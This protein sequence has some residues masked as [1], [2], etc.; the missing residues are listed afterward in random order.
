MSEST[1]LKWLIFSHRLQL[2]GL[3]VPKR[4]CYDVRLDLVRH[5]VGNP[6]SG[7]TAAQVHTPLNYA[8]CNINSDVNR[9]HF[10]LLKTV[11]HA[12]LVKAQYDHFPLVFII[13]HG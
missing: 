10:H 2:W 3:F 5:K 11:D 8:V 13:K 12:V 7:T 9:H 4:P 6:P 1:D